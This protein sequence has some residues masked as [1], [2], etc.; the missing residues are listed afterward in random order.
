MVLNTCYS[1]S[2][3]KFIN[4]LWPR[5]NHCI[6]SLKQTNPILRY[7]SPGRFHRLVQVY[8]QIIGRTLYLPL[9][10][11]LFQKKKLKKNVIS[12]I[13]KSRWKFKT[14]MWSVPQEKIISEG[15]YILLPEMCDLL[16]NKPCMPFS[17][18]APLFVK[19]N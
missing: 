19:I 2:N 17:H 11:E 16:Y 18:S 12:Y 6:F 9:E 1:A 5:W 4:I 13:A 8:R 15:A 10:E 7:K 14:L 3:R